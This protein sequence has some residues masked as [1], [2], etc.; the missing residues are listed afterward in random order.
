VVVMVAVVAM[1]EFGNN[2]WFKQGK[3]L[4][5]IYS[6]GSKSRIGEQEL[7]L[8]AVRVRVWLVRWTLDGLG[9]V[10]WME[11]GWIYQIDEK[12]TNGRTGEMDGRR[13]AQRTLRA[14][15]TSMS[16]TSAYNKSSSNTS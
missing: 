6:V 10:G 4:T 5:V 15:P 16:D 3:P 8:Y 7:P 12:E 13:Y 2:V 14:L 9:W 1:G 11:D